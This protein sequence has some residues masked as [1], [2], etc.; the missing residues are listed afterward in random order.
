[1]LQSWVLR[2]Q[3]IHT[4]GLL[5]RRLFIPLILDVREIYVYV[6]NLSVHV[7]SSVYSYSTRLRRLLRRSILTAVMP[8]PLFYHLL[9]GAYYPHLLP[10]R[11]FIG[12]PKSVTYPPTARII[13]G[14]AKE[15]ALAN[16]RTNDVYHPPSILPFAAS[17]LRCFAASLASPVHSYGD[18]FYPFDSWCSRDLLWIRLYFHLSNLSTYVFTILAY[19]SPS[20]LTL[21]DF[22]ACFAGP[23]LRRLRPG[24]FFS[25]LFVGAYYPHLLPSRCFIGG[26]KSLT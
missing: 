23:F 1:M 2:Y 21:R 24:S 14:R 15:W 17:L 9:V 12:G 13:M 10:S 8:G 16:E 7:Y 11:C 26:P 3:S 19:S 4:Y 20:I 5:L 18:L 25:V 6:S 22:V